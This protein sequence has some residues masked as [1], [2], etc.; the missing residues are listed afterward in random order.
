[1]VYFKHGIILVVG[2]PGIERMHGT[3]R[4]PK[5]IINSGAGPIIGCTL[6][7]VWIACPV[8]SLAKINSAIKTATMPK[9]G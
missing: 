2:K 9:L 5:D 1:M 6:G 8:R 7:L 3:K 4:A